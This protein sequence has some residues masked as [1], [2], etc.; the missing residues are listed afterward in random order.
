MFLAEVHP[1]SQELFQR[2]QDPP[3]C[4]AP[5]AEPKQCRQPDDTLSVSP[6]SAGLSEVGVLRDRLSGIVASEL[7]NGGSG[8]GADKRKSFRVKRSQLLDSIDNTIQAI[9]GQQVLPVLILAVFQYSLDN[10]WSIGNRINRR[11]VHIPED[12]VRKALYAFFL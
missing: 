11:P 9:I 8:N 5:V 6:K 12:V 4:D 1:E 10:V 7:F 3:I 2:N